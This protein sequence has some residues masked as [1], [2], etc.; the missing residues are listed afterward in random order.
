M[1]TT[2]LG[3]LR[4][5]Q[6]RS[7]KH[8]HQR[9]LFSHLFSLLG[10][11]GNHDDSRTG[12]PLI[13]SD[14]VRTHEAPRHHLPAIRTL[15]TYTMFMLRVGT[16]RPGSVESRRRSQIGH[17]KVWTTCHHTR[18]RRSGL[19]PRPTCHGPRVADHG[20]HTSRLA[21]HGPALVGIPTKRG[22][23]RP[24]F[25]L[26]EGFHVFFFFL[27][28][29]AFPFWLLLLCQPPH[30]SLLPKTDTLPY[31]QH[32]IRSHPTLTRPSCW[33]WECGPS[34]PTCSV[35]RIQHHSTTVYPQC[36]TTY[37]WQDPTGLVIS[38]EKYPCGV[39]RVHEMP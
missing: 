26:G 27:F 4:T 5:R 2:R 39:T 15:F 30:P 8:W 29:F 3:A 25:F 32:L 12:V 7:V 19:P 9:I 28:V 20:P 14:R 18:A 36:E 35:L 31:S 38:V 11:H 6:G 23:H 34:K 17:S 22:A 16:S 33:L 21:D 24:G 10:D 1:T 13:P 37:P